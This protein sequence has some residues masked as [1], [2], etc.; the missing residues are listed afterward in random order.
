[1]PEPTLKL[2]LTPVCVPSSTCTLQK[3]QRVSGALI[4]VAK[5]LGNLRFRVWEKMKDI[6]QFSEFYVTYDAHSHYVNVK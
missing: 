3:P 1:M 4:D 2:V 5:H 6:V